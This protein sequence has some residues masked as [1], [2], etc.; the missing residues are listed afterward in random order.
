MVQV[1]NYG[2]QTDAS[3]DGERVADINNAWTGQ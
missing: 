3:K 1:N 2:N